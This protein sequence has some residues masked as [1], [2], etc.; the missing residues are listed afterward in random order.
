M[1][2]EKGAEQ[3]GMQQVLVALG[4]NISCRETYLARACELIEERCGV[5]IAQSPIWETP[6]LGP[7]SGSFLNGAVL[8]G[9]RFDPRALMAEL[10]AIELAMGRVRQIKWGDRCIDLDIILWHNADGSDL[11][12]ASEEV[13]IPHP[14]AVH[15]DF[16]LEPAAAIA[17]DWCFPALGLTVAQLAAKIKKKGAN[18]PLYQSFAGLK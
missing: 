2:P 7:A 13:V 9:T 16:V 6:A 4:S 17:P 12:L 14:E 1:G 3:L 15:R 5:L 10:L 11:V 8:L 18:P